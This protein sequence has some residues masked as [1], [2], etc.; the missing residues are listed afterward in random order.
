MIAHA[1]L[2]SD[3]LHGV[4]FKIFMH[5]ECG[6]CRWQHKPWLCT[7]SSHPVAAAP[8][9]TKKLAERKRA[10]GAVARWQS[11]GDGYLQN[12]VFPDETC[13]TNASLFVAASVSSASVDF[14]RLVACPVPGD[15]RG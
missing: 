5:A 4:V 13:P 7:A 11:F 15:F 14:S 2:S 9:R 10:S 12:P 8:D 6:M 3:Q 1:W